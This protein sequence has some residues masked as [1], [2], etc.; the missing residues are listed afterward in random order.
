MTTLRQIIIDAMRESGTIAVGMTPDGEEHVEALRRLQTIISNLFGHELGEPLQSVNHED[1]RDYDEVPVNLRL[2]FNN[3]GGQ[4][5]LLKKNPRD[6]ARL[7]VIDNAGNFATYNTVV[8]GNGRKIELADLIT[9]NTN[10]VNREWFYRADLGNW[11]RVTDLTASSENP[12]P[13]EFDDFLVTLLA[14]RL[15]PRYGI[16]TKQETVDVVRRMRSQF[17]ARYR[18]VREEPVDEALTR[19]TSNRRYYRED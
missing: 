15:N 4:T 18:Q 10:L 7:G 11:A 17:R 2:V 16:E 12:F 13:K 8:K 3:E 1:I 19:L 9:L 14:L 6:G 5:I